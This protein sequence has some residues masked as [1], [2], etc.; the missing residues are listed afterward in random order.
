MNDQPNETAPTVQGA[1]PA[2]PAVQPTA[3][4]MLRQAR[5]M[6]GLHLE[7]V[8]A[9]LK[10]PVQKLAALEADDLTALP[11]PVF[12]RALAASVCRALRVDPAPVLAR[13]PG[14]PRAS[15]AQSDRAVG[16]AI[17][18]HTHRNA[19]L[20]RTTHG[21]SAPLI[22]VVALLLGAAALL[23]WVPQSAIDK[24]TAALAPQGG[25]SPSAQVDPAA[26]AEGAGAAA[27][28]GAASSQPPA[29]APVPAAT[30]SQPAAAEVAAT[31]APAPVA[32]PAEAVQLTAKGEAWVSVSEA[33][34]RVLQ[35][36]TLAS[37]ETLALSGK[38][39]LAVIIGRASAVDVLVH[40]KPFDLTPIARTGGVA[41][42]EVKAEA[43]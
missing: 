8:A 2:S 3:G 34:G 36:R 31:P 17:K 37:G 23:F 42:F 16:G 43:P 18:P 15:L 40:G 35:Q 24:V 39:P 20:G 7:V 41:R 14:A 29:T 26:A 19:G 21:I 25:R 12:A 30:A 5:E 1:V 28:D 10:V 22:V 33:G 6:H 11:D 27:A 38:L 32:A 4:Q 13:L 9:A